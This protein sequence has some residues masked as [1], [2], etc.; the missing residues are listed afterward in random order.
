W[1]GGF[2][3]RNF[4][5]ASQH[6]V[7]LLP[8]RRVRRSPPPPAAPPL[9]SAAYGRERGSTLP[10]SLVR[11]SSATPQ[12]QTRDSVAAIRSSTAPMTRAQ[13]AVATC[14]SYAAPW[15]RATERESPAPPSASP[16]LAHGSERGAPW[17][18]AA[19][20]C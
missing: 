10:L 8:H 4:L 17:P 9:L 19:L 7:S 12:T 1:I 14:L 15:M 3:S 13:T 11:S 5:S 6:V 16:L 20:L 18:P 2:L